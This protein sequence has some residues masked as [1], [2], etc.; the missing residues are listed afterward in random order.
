MS[1]QL[2]QHQAVRSDRSLEMVV[3][4]GGCIWGVDQSIVLNQ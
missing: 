4:E 1:I 2:N 3:L